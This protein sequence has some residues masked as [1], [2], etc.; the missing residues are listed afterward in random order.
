MTTRHYRRGR[1]KSRRSLDL[2]D[3]ARK[4]LAQ[5]QPATVRAVCYRLFVAGL[6]DSMEKKNTSKVSVQ[7][8]WAREQAIIPWPWI[9]DETREAE[10]VPSWDD[11]AAF[12]RSVS[13][14]YR[15]DN[16][17]LQDTLVE[18]WSEK[19]TMRGTLAPVLREYGV[20]F[21]VM[22]GF[23]SATSAYDVAQMIEHETDREVIIFYV[24]DW[25]PSGLYMSEADLPNRLLAYGA[26]P[27]TF[28]RLALTERDIAD[29]E[30]PS[31]Q[32][33]DKRKDPRYR[34][35]VYRYGSRCWE[36]D[37]LSPVVLRDRLEA[38]IR[39]EIDWP[40]WERSMR[41]E[42]AETESLND[43]LTAWSKAAQS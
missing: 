24:G 4:I 3:A 30:L 10:G 19:G 12:A 42:Q 29:R 23:T 13:R 7:L 2:I 39:A 14:Q 6:I 32:A 43:V 36:L 31:F 41:A 1:G 16:W 37:A 21:R 8:T 28:V 38:A 22:H 9:V 33:S 25:D 17:R 18:V 5:I 34:W 40:A 11:P 20:T 27:D 35:F 15:R 26:E